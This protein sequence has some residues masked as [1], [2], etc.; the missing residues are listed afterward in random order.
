MTNAAARLKVVKI[1]FRKKSTPPQ[2]YSTSRP[3]ARWSS[4]FIN[5]RKLLAPG[6]PGGNCVLAFS[7]PLFTPS[8]RLYLAHSPPVSSSQS[9]ILS[10]ARAMLLSD[11]SSSSIGSIESATR[12]RMSSCSSTNT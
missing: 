5:V 2:F 3:S 4:S 9:A 6:A 7:H 11:T 1:R 10:V 12:L 8:S